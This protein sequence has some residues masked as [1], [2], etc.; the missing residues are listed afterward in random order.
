MKPSKEETVG[1]RD[2]NFSPLAKGVFKK[3]GNI[4]R[5]RTQQPHVTTH[6]RALVG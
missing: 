5:V 4:S 1:L 2:R 3:P 6:V